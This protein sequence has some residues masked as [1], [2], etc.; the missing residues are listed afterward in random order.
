MSQHPAPAWAS[1]AV[2]SGP[3]VQMIYVALILLCC[4]QS[5]CCAF[6]GDFEVSPTWL[7]FLSV[8]WPPRKWVPFL[9]LSS[10]SRMLVLSWFLF[11]LSFSFVLSSYIE[12]FLPFLE[13]LNSASIQLFCASCF[14]CK[15]VFLRCLWEKVSATSYSSAILFHPSNLKHFIW[16]SQEPLGLEKTSSCFIIK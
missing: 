16:C 13:V 9:F 4:S 8:R 11:S 7:I 14:I 15:S 3:V 2:V 12:S 5:S 6:L 1:Q 10:L